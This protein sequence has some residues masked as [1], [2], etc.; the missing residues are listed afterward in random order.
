MTILV[1]L[2]CAYL[3]CAP[4]PSFFGMEEQA[5]V[6]IDGEG[7]YYWA[8]KCEVYPGAA[9]RNGRSIGS[10]FRKRFIA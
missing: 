2:E 10:D 6:K 8:R 3:L 7:K 9:W 5:S 4:I 1:G